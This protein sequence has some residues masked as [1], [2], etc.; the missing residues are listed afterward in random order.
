MLSQE[1]RD[2]NDEASELFQ[3]A[4]DLDP[5]YAEAYAALGGSYL[6]A[7]VS[8]WSEFRTQDLKRA[9]ELAQ[10]ALALDSATTRA[11]RVLALIG[12]FRKRCRARAD[13]SRIRDQSERCGQ[14]CLPR[15][16]FGLGRQGHRGIAVVGMCASL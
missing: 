9:E 8:G 7:V 15:G 14:L 1:T 6:E 11:Y 4:I 2:N 3:R 5:N 10:K 13:R 12:L 16:H